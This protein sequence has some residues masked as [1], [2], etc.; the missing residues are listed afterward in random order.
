MPPRPHSKVTSLSSERDVQLLNKMTAS[1][2][3]VRRLHIR[4][5]DCVGQT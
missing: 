5:T 1:C 4:W 2:L 3:I